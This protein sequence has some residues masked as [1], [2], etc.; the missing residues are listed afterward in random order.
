MSEIRPIVAIDLGGTNFRVALIA[1]DGTI[2]DSVK[3]DSRSE[4]GPERVIE[5]IEDVANG[6][7]R[8]G[9]HAKLMGVGAA[10]AGPITSDGVI[11]HPP[12][13]VGWEVVPFKAMLEKRFDAPVWVGN[14]ANVACLGV[15]AFGVGKGIDDLI[16]MT[17]STGVG[18][19][20]LTGGKLVTGWKGMAAEIGHIIIDR[21][22]AKANCGHSGCLESL[23]SGTSIAR[24][25]REGL[26]SGEQ[27][28]LREVV[29]GDVADV[30]AEHVFQAAAA[31]DPYSVALVRQ[32]AWDLSMGIVGLVHIFNPKLFVLGGGVTRDWHLLAPDVH[33]AMR[34][35]TFPEFL[36]DFDIT[37]STFGD[38]VGLVG[39]AALVLRES[40]ALPT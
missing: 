7:L 2:L 10:V 38:D 36:A 20:V 28:S 25:A 22:R 12:N 26:S 29:G 19:G 40:G 23:V 14:D 16:Y 39:A 27:S 13:L 6:M 5:R 18:G 32:V 9:G 15:Q 33:V 17:V 11:Y 31:G 4:E 3:E 21:S 24:I 37:L 1:A 8:R 35:Q 34:Q 30:R